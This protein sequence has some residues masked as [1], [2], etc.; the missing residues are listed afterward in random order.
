M[1]IVFPFMEFGD[2]R[3]NPS[4]SFCR[5]ISMCLVRG[6]EDKRK[7]SSI[8]FLGIVISSCKGKDFCADLSRTGVKDW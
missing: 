5:G 7:V 2:V 1:E 3:C 6:R 4:W 8:Y